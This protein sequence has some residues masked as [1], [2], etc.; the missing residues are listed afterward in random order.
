MTICSKSIATQVLLLAFSTL[1]AV[2]TG[3]LAQASFFLGPI[4][5][6]MQNVGIIL[7]GLLLPPKHA[8]F[9]QLLYIVLIALGLPMA[10]G[11]KGGL[12][13]LL[14]YTGGYIAGFPIASFLMS[15]FTR[16]YLNLRKIKLYDVGVKDF[17]ALLLLSVVA[18]LPIYILGFIVFAYYALSNKNLFSWVIKVSNV[19]GFSSNDRILA[20]FLVSVA[21]FIPQDVLMDHVIA[22]STAKAISSYLKQRGVVI[23]QNC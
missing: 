4:P 22:I 6:T 5:Y 21:I 20:I 17:I 11:F 3:I 14:G 2:L 7:G 23:E 12:H 16:A 1:I 18:A 8:L 9:S 15:I 13:V 10:S 19:I